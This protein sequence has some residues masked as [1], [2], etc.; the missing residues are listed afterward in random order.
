MEAL[1]NAWALV[2][3]GSRGIGRAI[4]IELARSGAKVVVNYHQN[5]E[6]AKAVVK[7]IQDLGKEAVAIQANVAE[8]ADVLRM[9]Q[10]VENL[11]TLEVLVCNAG[12][13]KD[14][15]LLRMSLADFE[16]VVR[17]N[18]TGTFLCLR[19]AG[20]IMLRKRYGRIITLSSISGIM[21]NAGQAPYSASKAGII[22]LTKTFARE[23]AK[24]DVTANV[25]APGYIETDMTA[26]LSEEIKAKMISYIPKQRLG[27]VQEVAHCVVFLASKEAGY[28]TGQVISPNGGLV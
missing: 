16:D 15:L 26:Q 5:E 21:G 3:G 17:T 10:N 19:Q 13:T 14:N 24:T 6:A 27:T 9:F 7:E 11:G 18:L 22:A 25:V 12:I 20:K 4:A 1:N 2:T 28:I 8:E 23:F